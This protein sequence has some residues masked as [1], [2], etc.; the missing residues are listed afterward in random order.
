MTVSLDGEIRDGR[1]HMQVRI[2]FEDTD[3]GQIVYHANFLRFMERGR[4]NYLRLLVT[5]QQELLKEAQEDAPGFAF[6]VRSMSIDFLKPAIL[7]DLL[8]VVTVPEEVRGA[9]ITLLQECRR[10]D[11]LLVTARVRAAFISGGKAQ[12]IPKGLRF[13]MGGA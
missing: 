13:A 11:D 9:S 2:Y 12:R 3:A 6:V 8:E 7:D 4:T 1:H 5:D 10:G